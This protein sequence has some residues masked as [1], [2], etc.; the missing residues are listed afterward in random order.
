M[1]SLKDSITNHFP[2]PTLDP[3][4]TDTPSYQSSHAIHVQLN[5]N[6]ASI[7]S[8]LFNCQLR[9]LGLTILRHDYKTLSGDVEFTRPTK[10]ATLTIPSSSTEAQIAALQVAHTSK[11]ATW[12][13]CISTD[14]ALKTLLIQEIPD[15]YMCG[16]KDSTTVYTDVNTRKLLTRLYTTYITITALALTNNDA[17]MRQPFTHHEPIDTFFQCMENSRDFE[18][19]GDNE[20]YNKKLCTI[21]FHAFI[22][23]RRYHD[24]CREWRKRRTPHTS[25]SRHTSRQ[26]MLSS[27]TFLPQL[28]KRGFTRHRLQSIHWFR[29]PMTPWP[30]SHPQSTPIK[31]PYN[32]CS[33][34]HFSTSNIWTAT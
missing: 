14:A 18:D 9:L 32:L 25:I 12:D 10:L 11:S 34:Q 6:A 8:T 30:H 17:E 1:S 19:E 20:Y 5:A 13:E 7:S 24:M 29:T 22:Q 2:H 3:V 23:T 15:I 16:V 21:T 26:P 33:D 31:P 28:R 27:P 4:I